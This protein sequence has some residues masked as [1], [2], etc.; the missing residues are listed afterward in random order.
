[1]RRF[2]S[3]PYMLRLYGIA[4]LLMGVFVSVYN[5]LTF[6]LE[7][8]PF[9]LHHIFVAFI[10]LMY[11]FGVFGTMATSRLVK[12][13]A[14]GNIL[15]AFIISMFIGA[16]MLLSRQIYILIIGLALLTFS[17]L[18]YTLWPA[19]WLL[20]TLKKVKVRPH[21]FTGWY[22]TLAPVYWE[23]EQVI[24]CTQLPG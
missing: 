11:T 7:A 1:M 9:S 15:K 13:Y 12:K 16:L 10:F 19:E 17:F 8:P 5:Y 4:A 18:L 21:L 14:P 2:L 23:A 24:F 20:C 6:R 3:D 22:I